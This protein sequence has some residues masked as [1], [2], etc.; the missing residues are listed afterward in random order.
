MDAAAAAASAAAEQA[1]RRELRERVRIG[2]SLFVGALIG[3]AV[4]SLFDRASLQIIL[5]GADGLSYSPF[6]VEVVYA[7]GVLGLALGFPVAILSAKLSA[8]WLCVFGSVGSTMGFLLLWSATMNHGWYKDKAVLFALYNFIAGHSLAYLYHTSLVINMKNMKP[9]IGLASVA[10]N[11]PVVISAVTLW[12]IVQHMRLLFLVQL[13]LSVVASFAGIAMLRAKKSTSTRPTFNTAR[14]RTAADV[15]ALTTPAYEYAP[16]D[17]E[18]LD[19]V[20]ADEVDEPPPPPPTACDREPLATMERRRALELWALSWRM[21]RPMW[22]FALAAAAASPMSTEQYAAPELRVALAALAAILTALYVDA[23]DAMPR[24]NVLLFV[25][26][27][28]CIVLAVA[29][30]DRGL[31]GIDGALDVSSGM[32]LGVLWVLIPVIMREKFGSRRLVYVWSTTLLVYVVVCAVQT[33]LSL[34]LFNRHSAGAVCL[35]I[36]CPLLISMFRL[37]LTLCSMIW[38]CG[39]A[40]Y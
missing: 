33:A 18:S 36:Q 9:K 32:V 26:C 5:T 7:C 3:M 38:S 12:L 4:G 31:R 2:G 25:L 15:R 34:W 30:G 27:A 37:A 20:S 6:E 35:G 39:L 19:D 17:T 16:S 13:G 40:S 28:R 21:Q 10:L 8:M 29:V 24:G 23:F 14:R 22:A 1:R 11:G